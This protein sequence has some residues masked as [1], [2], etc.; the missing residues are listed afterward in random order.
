RV[1]CGHEY[2]ANNLKY[3]R[4][5]EGNNADIEHKLKWALDK[6]RLRE[7]TVPSTIGEEKKINPFM[8]VNVKEVQ[9]HAKQ[10]DAI[11]TMAFLRNEKDKFKA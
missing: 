5:V 2:T 11:K 1:Y 9:E 6:G 3:A 4:H 8:R 7:S 10:T